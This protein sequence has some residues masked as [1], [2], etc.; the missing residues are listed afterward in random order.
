M[1]AIPYYCGVGASLDMMDLLDFSKS[2]I[3]TFVLGTTLGTFL[4]LYLYIFT[5]QKISHKIQLMTKNINFI[6]AIL[7]GVLGVITLINLLS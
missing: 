6:L 4:I 7:T 1:F 3:L 2:T 5:A